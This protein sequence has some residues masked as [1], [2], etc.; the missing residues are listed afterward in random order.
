MEG[1][2]SPDRSCGDPGDFPGLVPVDR[3]QH[4][5]EYHAVVRMELATEIGEQ[6]VRAALRVS[7]PPCRHSTA[8][9][10]QVGRSDLAEP[11]R[12]TPPA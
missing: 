11:H 3:E 4:C 6:L 12:I 9:P 5:S 8:G 7:S 10:V 1:W 2:C